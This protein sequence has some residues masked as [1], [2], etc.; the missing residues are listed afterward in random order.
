MKITKKYFVKIAA[1]CMLLASAN[2]AFAHE[3]CTNETFKGL[4]GVEL[5]GIAGGLFPTTFVFN[6]VV[7]GQGGIPSGAG[8]QGFP[9]LIVNNI[10]LVGN[11][12]VNPDCSGRLKVTS[13]DGD[14]GVE[15]FVLLDGGN[16][17][18][19]IDDIPGDILTGEGERISKNPN[20]NCSTDLIRGTYA[21]SES[22]IE[23]GT[24]QLAF[25]GKFDAD[26]KGNGTNGSGTAAIGR[27]VTNNLSFTL[28]YTVNAD[29]S[30]SLALAN[31]SPAFEAK[32]FNFVI[33]QGGNKLLL[34]DT[35]TGDIETAVAYRQN[36]G[37]D[38][39]DDR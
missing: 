30:G 4:Y 22:G 27:K 11:Y 33:L 31:L 2:L 18:V 28:N 32:T 29:C 39:D 19:L 36:R 7:D 14:V 38:S 13:N 20:T 12:S 34:I 37:G 5:T 23:N 16:R 9:G 15:N 25:V 8:T 21:F 3:R 6:F 26:G 10:T 1:V 24:A 17:F 35:D